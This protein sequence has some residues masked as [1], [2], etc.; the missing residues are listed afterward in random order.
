MVRFR[1][2]KRLNIRGLLALRAGFHFERHTL[3]L[4][5]GLEPLHPDFGEMGK[6]ILAAIVRRNKA[7]ALSIVKPFHDT[8]IHIPSSPLNKNKTRATPLYR[9]TKPRRF[10]HP[11]NRCAGSTAS[12][13]L[14]L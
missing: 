10:L 1:R 14:L 5:K 9:H 6:Q 4:F 12:L 13:V 2:S 7:E 3:I 8:G 11:L